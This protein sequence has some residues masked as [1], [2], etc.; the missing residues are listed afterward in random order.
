MPT[1]K[2]KL[3]MDW[4]EAIPGDEFKLGNASIIIEP[5]GL[6]NLIHITKRLRSV[7]IEFQAAGITWENY[8][9][10]E[11]LTTVI[12]I[13][14][15]NCP[16]VL[17]IASGIQQEDIDRLPLTLAMELAQKLV[18]VNLKS[19]ADLEK[20]FKSLAE[21]IGMNLDEMS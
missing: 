6:K 4:S 11:M 19:K 15:E 14:L 9:T 1:A 8:S 2:K 17:S 21:M 18:E 3:N 16:E 10:P 13:V 12:S 5:L 20:N 7:A